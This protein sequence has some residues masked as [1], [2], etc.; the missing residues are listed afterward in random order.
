[1]WTTSVRDIFRNSKL[2]RSFL[3]A[4]FSL[5]FFYTVSVDR[6]L[7][8]TLLLLSLLLLL[9]APKVTP[10]AVRDR[11]DDEGRVF[12]L[13]SMYMYPHICNDLR[14]DAPARTPFLSGACTRIFIRL[15]LML[16]LCARARGD[17]TDDA[18]VKIKKPIYTNHVPC[19]RI[20]IGSF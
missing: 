10:A 6:I 9:Y 13:F 14:D 5:I 12:F 4:L 11:I 20:G 7:R 3:F 1:M 17:K 2:R 16:V 8:T 19:T 15:K 18:D